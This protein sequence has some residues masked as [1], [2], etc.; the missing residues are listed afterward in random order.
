MKEAVKK[1]LLSIGTPKETISA[2][3]AETVP[4]DFVMDE[5]VNGFIKLRQ[6]LTLNN[7]EILKSLKQ[8]FNGEQFPAIINPIVKKLRDISGLSTED[9]QKLIKDG[10]SHVD[11]KTLIDAVVGKLKSTGAASVDEQKQKIFDLQ[12][13]IDDMKN[14]YTEKLTNAEKSADNRVK[15]FK[16]GIDFVKEMANHKS[17]ITPEATQSVIEAWMN[18]RNINLD[19]DPETNQLMP[20]NADG[21]KYS[22]SK[23]FLNASNLI[24]SAMEESKI[25]VVS[26]GGGGEGGTG[27]GK[28]GGGGNGAK[29]KNVL[30]LEERIKKANGL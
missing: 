5:A 8:K 20:F 23:G 22:D 14:E 3:E 18:K 30:S 12:K 4:D 27:G 21:T 17:M 16:I 9:V 1:Y 10:D 25:L 29:D 13:S 15:K 7:S 11:V 24:K 6:D 19:Y 2:L 26:N 28:G